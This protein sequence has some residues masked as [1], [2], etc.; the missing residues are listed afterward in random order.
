MIFASEK[1]EP[2]PTNLGG[3]HS[4]PLLAGRLGLRSGLFYCSR[5]ALRP[6][7]LGFALLETL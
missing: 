6:N 7:E 5:L 1:I 4:E 2:A 3:F